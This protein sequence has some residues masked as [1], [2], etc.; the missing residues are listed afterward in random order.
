MKLL[1]LLAVITVGLVVWA[2]RTGTNPLRWF[3]GIPRRDWLRYG[4]PTL[5]GYAIVY[6]SVS[7]LNAI[8][9]SN[10][11]RF[12]SFVSHPLTAFFF[13]V[14]ITVILQASFITEFAVVF[15]AA[16]L[17]D[18]PTAVALV[19]GGNVGTCVTNTVV[20]FVNF[21]EQRHFQ[22]AFS[23][24]I[25]HDLFNIFMVLLILPAELSTGFF[26]RHVLFL[27]RSVGATGAGPA[28]DF[29][30]DALAI[31]ATGASYLLAA[32]AIVATLA[33][34]LLIV[35]N[36]KRLFFERIEE[37]LR[38]AVFTSR[39]RSIGC[40]VGFTFL[41]QSSSLSTS[42][43]VPFV[44]NGTVPLREALYYLLGCNVGTALVTILFTVPIIVAGSANGTAVALCHLV[45][46]GYGL[47]LF[48]LLPPLGDGLCLVAERIARG[49]QSW[50]RLRLGATLGGIYYGGPAMILVACVSLL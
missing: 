13:S 34:I 7:Y 27:A 39:G 28:T 22:R 12:L 29:L 1:I 25:V 41:V 31:D 21:G 40:G 8:F 20:S 26:S 35:L 42:M 37:L 4:L 9:T 3:A 24:S 47:L 10:E 16:G 11:L 46:N 18:L 19:L 14:L 30:P 48:V 15:A 23:A 17:V 2:A 36:L 32:I 33:G 6:L 5:L 45:F 38:T 44:G 43:V 49:V 50:T